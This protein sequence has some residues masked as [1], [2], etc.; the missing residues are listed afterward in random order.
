MPLNF[1]SLRSS[2]SGNCLVVKTENTIVVIDC[3]LSSIRATRKILAQSIANPKYIDLVLISHL[4][5]DHISYYPLRVLEDEGIKLK[6]HRDCIEN[7]NNKHLYGVGLKKLKLGEYD[8]KK[9]NVGD[10]EI[11]PFEVPHHPDYLTCGFV[12]YYKDK[13]IVIATDFKD[14]DGQLDYFADADFIFVES[15]HDLELLRKYFNP[16]SLYHL[17]NPKTAD[18]LCHAL[19]KSK[20]IPQVIMLGHLSEQR[21]TPQIAIKEIKTAFKKNGIDNGLRILT[22]PPDKCSEVINL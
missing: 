20:K 22:A 12:I 10:L 1:Q 8:T 5:S 19:K 18:L 3:G 21:N 17:P 6:V 7:L 13:K 15:N 4:H 16:N 9:F 2:S 14:W 11:E